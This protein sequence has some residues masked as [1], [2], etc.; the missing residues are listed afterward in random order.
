MRTW[1]LILD[2]KSLLQRL[3]PTE[4]QSELNSVGRN[5]AKRN[6]RDYKNIVDQHKIVYS[7]CLGN[8][9]F[10]ES[11]LGEI[12]MSHFQNFIRSEC[13]SNNS[14]KM[15]IGKCNSFNEW[16]Q[17]VI[18]KEKENDWFVI[19]FDPDS[20]KEISKTEDKRAY[21]INEVLEKAF[22]NQIRRNSPDVKMRVKNNSDAEICRSWFQELF[23]G[24]TKIDIFDLYIMK[25]SSYCAFED[26][27]LSAIDEGTEVRIY[28]DKQNYNDFINFPVK[29][30]DEIGKNAYKPICKRLERIAQRKKLKIKFFTAEGRNYDKEHDR[31]IFI[32]P[33]NI[34][35]T[36]GKGVDF[37]NYGTMKT[38]GTEIGVFED[39]ETPASIQEEYVMNKNIKSPYKPERT[40]S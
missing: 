18:A 34:H 13:D 21:T 40:F 27:I 16:I 20:K 19:C 8:I 10:A 26:Y 3:L 32:L 31:H 28:T 2:E 7:D 14:I 36:I 6:I 12:Y 37:I 23:H 35:V 1:K 33:S 25:E 24:E 5:K 29:L 11:G 4:K 39:D 17:K 9:L 30:K 22:T 15:E 38:E